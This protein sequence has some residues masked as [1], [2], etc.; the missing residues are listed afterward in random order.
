VGRAHD[1]LAVGGA[2]VQPGPGRRP[3][4]GAVPYAV[5]ALTALAGGLVAILRRRTRRGP[6]HRATARRRAAAPETS[7]PSVPDANHRELT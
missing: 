6:A 7:P 3:G 1:R 4:L 5:A 2:R